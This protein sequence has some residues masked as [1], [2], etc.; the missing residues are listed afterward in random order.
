M[1]LGCVSTADFSCGRS[2]D[3]GAPHHLAKLQGCCLHLDGVC[4]Q[5][6]AGVQPL[7]WSHGWAVLGTCMRTELVL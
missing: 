7:V 5:R 6:W 1:S 4:Q 2:S 3:Y